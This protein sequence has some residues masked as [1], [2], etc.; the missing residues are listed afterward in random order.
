M[1]FFFFILQIARDYNCKKKNTNLPSNV[2]QY[3]D[4][5]GPDPQPLTYELILI[6]IALVLPGFSVTIKVAYDV[7]HNPQK[8]QRATLRDHLLK[9]NF[10]YTTSNTAFYLKMHLTSFFIDFL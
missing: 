4:L 7:L 5:F 3:T 2:G 6:K 10:V 1:R 9:S 8:S